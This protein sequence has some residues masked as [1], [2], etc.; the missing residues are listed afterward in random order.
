MLKNFILCTSL[1]SVSLFAQAEPEYDIILLAPKGQ[2]LT[3]KSERDDT[4][5]IINDAG[6]VGGALRMGKGHDS[7]TPFLYHQD[8]GFHLIPLPNQGIYGH[9]DAINKH[10]I[11]VGSYKA[12]DSTYYGQS[13]CKY[14]VYDAHTQVCYDLLERFDIKDLTVLFH[15]KYYASAP[16]YTAYITDENQIMIKSQDSSWENISKASIFELDKEF[17]IP[18]LVEDFITV[19][20]KGHIIGMKKINSEEE[21]TFVESSWFFDPATGKQEIGS[22]DIFDRWKVMPELL[23]PNGIVAGIGHNSYFDEKGFIWSQN[24]G[25][26]QVDLPEYSYLNKVNDKGHLIGDFESSS[27]SW[28]YDPW[29][30]DSNA[31]PSIARSAFLF[32]PENGFT[33]LGSQWNY[34]EPF[35]INNHTQVVGTYDNPQERA[36]IWDSANGMRD[37]T[38]LIPKNTGWKVLEYAIDINDSGYIVGFGKYYG[39]SQSFL[40]VPRRQNAELVVPEK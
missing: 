11:A 25:F 21:E 17:S 36:F 40:L 5:I 8:L 15:D 6:Y 10:G 20:P 37:L 30:T 13:W 29:D 31:T 9:V 16:S 12:K 4:R 3:T 19:N 38:F 32:T 22:L 23:S 2:E 7:L 28:T 24:E 27:D 35:G 1:F 33:I 39:V 18:L 34:T 26:T 14:F